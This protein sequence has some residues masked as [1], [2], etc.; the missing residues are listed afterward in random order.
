MKLSRILFGGFSVLI[1]LVIGFGFFTISQ[2]N[3]LDGLEEDILRA[4]EIRVVALDF[5]VENYQTQ[6]ELL[7]YAYA[8]TDERLHQQPRI[9]DGAY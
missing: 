9:Q 1:L 5:N 3:G 4:E 8:P 2:L 7:E 6:L